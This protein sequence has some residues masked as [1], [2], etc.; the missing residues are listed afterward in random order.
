MKRTIYFTL[1]FALLGLAAFLFW[2]TMRL[3]VFPPVFES[4]ARILVGA[5]SPTPPAWSIESDTRSL[6]SIGVLSHVITNL[7]LA[8]RWG[9][10]YKDG[11]LRIDT[12]YAILRSRLEIK[13]LEN[14]N[15]IEIRAR[16]GEPNEAAAIANAIAKIGTQRLPNLDAAEGTTKTNRVTLIEEA[17]PELRPI[18]PNR[19]QKLA[20]PISG[21]T[22]IIFGVAFL[23]R[24]SMVPKRRSRPPLRS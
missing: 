22:A 3:L 24:A 15:I 13:G 5:P 18:S 10:M 6:Q 14:S 23:I 4:T 20:F 1:G 16:S 11:P 17:V 2:S 21:C 12:T 9:E 19:L 7:D 8:R